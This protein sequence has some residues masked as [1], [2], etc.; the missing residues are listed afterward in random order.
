MEPAFVGEPFPV[1]QDLYLGADSEASAPC[2]FC[3]LLT[4]FSSRASQR[5][6]GMGNF[7]RFIEILQKINH[8]VKNHVV[9]KHMLCPKCIHL[10]NQCLESQRYSGSVL[11]SSDPSLRYMKNQGTHR[12]VIPWVL[13]S[14]ASWLLLS[15]LQSLHLFV[16]STMSRVFSCT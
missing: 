4:P 16:L 6:T 7:S 5:I 2:V 13:R 11:A 1:A 12:H 3:S 8:I 14:L 15:T 10:R 9:T